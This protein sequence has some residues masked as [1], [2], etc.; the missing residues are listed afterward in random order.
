MEI[1]AE[2]LSLHALHAA[3]FPASTTA[4]GSWRR[5][6]ASSVLSGARSYLRLATLRDHSDR[7]RELLARCQDAV[8]RFGGGVPEPE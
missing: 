8:R 4:A 2:L 6:V 3:A 7:S 1:A 5:V